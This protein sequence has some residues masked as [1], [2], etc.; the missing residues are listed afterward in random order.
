MGILN[1]TQTGRTNCF[2][3]EPA[4]AYD[5][6]IASRTFDFLKQSGPRLGIVESRIA[7]HMVVRKKRQPIPQS[8]EFQRWSYDETANILL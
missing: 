1:S 8:V 6:G 3:K 2:K 4:D 5:Q 7:I